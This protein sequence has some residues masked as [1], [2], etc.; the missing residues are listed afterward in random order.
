MKWMEVIGIRATASNREILEAKLQELV[1]EVQKGD[2]ALSIKVLHRLSIESDLCV[3]L[4][5]VSE[6]AEPTGSRLGLRLA[7]EMKAFGLVH[8]SVWAETP[9]G[10]V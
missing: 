2:P 4:H 3:H 5:H 9:G 6:K 10:H 8:H 1:G 7:A